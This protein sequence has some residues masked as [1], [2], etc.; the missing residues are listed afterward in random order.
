MY[1]LSTHAKL[2]LF[3]CGFQSKE[4]KRILDEYASKFDSGY[5]ESIITKKKG[6]HNHKELFPSLPSSWQCMKPSTNKYY[7][8]KDLTIYNIITIVIREYM[9][10]SKDELSSI[11]LLNTNF[12]EM[13]PKLQQWLQIELSLL[14]KPQLNHESQ[15][16]IDPHRVSMANAAMAHFGHDP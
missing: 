4:K 12:T 3:N 11:N 14:H 16:K 13:I 5:Q 15:T 6:K 2:R 10:F 1:A 9:T 7:Q 8:V